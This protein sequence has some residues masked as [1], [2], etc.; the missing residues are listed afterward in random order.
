MREF[1]LTNEDVGALCLSLASLLHAGIGTGDSLALMAQDEE[2]PAFRQ[3]LSDMA[4]RA[5]EGAALSAAF[6]MSGCIPGY[7]CGLLEVG[8]KVGKTEQTLEALSRH[9]AGRGRLEKQLRA[10][11]LYP[12]VL[13]LVML[14]VVMSLLMWVLPVF[15]DV[16]A[17]LGGGLTGVAGGLLMLGTALRKMLPALVLTLGLL[18]AI[19]AAVSFQPDLRQRVTTACRRVWG[20]RGAA[21]K[22]QTAR[23]VQALSLALSS[24]MTDQE[25]VELAMLLAGEETPV[26]QRCREC[27]LYLEQGESLA[28]ALGK[29]GLLSRSQCRLLEAGV[30]S[31]QGERVMAQ[32]ADH[33][34]EESEE[35]L[36]ELVS[37]I[38]PTLVVITSLLVGV[39]LLTVMLPLMHLMSSIG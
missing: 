39:I 19:L 16:Y 31:G 29:A 12:S 22:I 38:E 10:A 7:V 36:E 20:R 14:A 4:K 23:A 28:A 18:L 5:D 3:M 33:Q 34:L 24:G 37:R 27:A 6:R 21:G 26:H 11:L 15:D 13:L 32:I 30:R 9:Y 35:A 1:K 2:T 25:A 17:Q 8:E